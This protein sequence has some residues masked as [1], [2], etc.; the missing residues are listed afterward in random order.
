MEKTYV[1]AKMAVN[2]IL[3]HAGQRQGKMKIFKSG[4]PSAIISTC[5]ELFSIYP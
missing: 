2:L 4:T 3:D 5:R 1:A